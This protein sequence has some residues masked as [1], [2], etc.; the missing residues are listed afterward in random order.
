MAIGH[1]NPSVIDL[2]PGYRA[3][4]KALDQ[5]RERTQEKADKERLGQMIGDV[6]FAISWLETGRKPGQMRGVERRYERSWDPAWIDSYHSPSGWSIERESRDLT[7]EERFKIE[8]AMRDLS[9]RERQCFMLYHVDGLSE[10][11]IAQELHLGRSTVQ[12]FLERAKQ[13]IENAKVNSLFLLE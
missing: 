3:T 1:W 8:E 10:Y 13:K 11:E 9:T 6:E 5:A 2:I 12:K 7:D 4:R